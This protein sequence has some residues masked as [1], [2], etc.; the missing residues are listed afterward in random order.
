MNL[1]D[2]YYGILSLVNNFNQKGIMIL[3]VILVTAVVVIMAAVAYT[4]LTKIK[5]AQV[6]KNAVEDIVAAANKAKSETLASLESSEYGVQFTSSSVVIFKGQSY[7]DADHSFDEVLSII[8]PAG[9][10]NIN[11]S[12]GGTDFYFERLSGMPSKTGTVTVSVAGSASLTKTITVS[13]TG[14]LSVN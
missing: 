7:V 1:G 9:I 6:L 13:A 14:S 5:Q 8:S 2:F 11:L 12:S 4:E 10:S 3:E